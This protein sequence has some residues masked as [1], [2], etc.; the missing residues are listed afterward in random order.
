M[1]SF[2]PQGIVCRMPQKNPMMHPISVATVAK[3][4]VLRIPER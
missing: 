4:N 1:F 2:G 3:I